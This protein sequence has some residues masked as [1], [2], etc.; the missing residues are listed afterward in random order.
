MKEAVVTETLH[1]QEAEALESTEA[2]E[3]TQLGQRYMI[4]IPKQVM[5]SGRKETTFMPGETFREGRSVC[6]TCCIRHIF[7]GLSQPSSWKTHPQ[8]SI[9]DIVS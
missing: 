8:R 4:S 9:F 3:V 7:C 2:T 5:I 6:S 1:P